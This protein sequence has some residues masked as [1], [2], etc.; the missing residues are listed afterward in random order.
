MK[1]TAA[2]ALSLSAAAWFV[3]L[4]G[5]LWAFGI[6]IVGLYGVGAATGNWERWN[7]VLPSG[8]GYTRGDTAGNLAL[9]VHLLMA[10]FVTFAGAMQLVPALRAK[11]PAYHRWNGRIFIAVA[12][13][14]AGS[15]L[16]IALTRGAVA[17]VYMAVGNTLNAVLLMTCAG[18]ALKFA[19]KRRFDLHRR[20]ALR[21]FVL[22]LGVF[23]YRLGMM[24][25]F[26]ANRGPVGHT[27]AF[28]GPFDIFLAFAHVLLP[29]AVLELYLL[30]RDKGGVLAKWAMA[31]GMTVATLATAAGGLLAAIGLW[32]PRL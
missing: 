23:F 25:W 10:V 18:L 19:V 15:G 24:L 7:A 31:G 3:A 32:L 21:A 5:G 16:Y 27:D 1:S 26:V 11:A 20:W 4:V 28:D 6:Y 30:A 17:G 12:F 8:H 22:M 14:I 9:G 13:A 2:K 29:L